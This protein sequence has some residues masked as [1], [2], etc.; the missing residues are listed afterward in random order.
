M[1]T[2][3]AGSNMPCSRIHRRRA[4]TTSARFC[5]CAYRVF[6]EADVAPCEEPPHC[7]TAASDLSLAHDRDDLVQRHIRLPG[8]QRQQ[9]FCVLLQ[10]RGAATARLRRNAAGFLEALRPNHHHAGTDPIVFGRLTPRGSRR[11]VFDHPDTKLLGIGL[12]HRSL[13]QNESMPEDSLIDRHLGILPDSSRAKCALTRTTSMLRPPTL[14][15][16][17]LVGDPDRGTTP[18]LRSGSPYL[19]RSALSA[20]DKV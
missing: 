17:A 2:S 19:G 13:P 12:R 5:S 18:P 1:N 6:F 20:E 8:N 4:R 7:G 3:R 10:W 9:K 14:T 15:V 11:Y 16:S